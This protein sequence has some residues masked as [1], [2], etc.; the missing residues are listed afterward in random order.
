MSE[1]RDFTTDPHAGDIIAGT[2]PD[3]EGNVNGKLHVWSDRF[4]YHVIVFAD[5]VADARRIALLNLEE[6]DE[7]DSAGTRAI[8]DVKANN[9]K[10]WQ[11]N[12]VCFIAIDQGGEN[13][14]AAF[15]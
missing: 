15:S 1:T 9:P 11:H 7:P 6:P 14:T 5:S 13:G 8:A 4:S 2:A 3:G 12:P 10:I